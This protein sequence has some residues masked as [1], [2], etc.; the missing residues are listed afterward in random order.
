VVLFV[1]NLLLIPQFSYMACAWAGLIAYT[2]S[3]LLSYFIG[4]KYFPV[5]Y[6]LRDIAIYTV[7]AGILF[8]AMML[9]VENT[10]LALGY[11]TVLLFLFIGFIFR[12]E[13]LGQML[14]KA[15]VIGRFFKR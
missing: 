2:V 7:V 4:Q 8:A 15:P 6:P 11:R 9:P 13:H 10:W 5:A 12:K 3:M 1:I 14:A